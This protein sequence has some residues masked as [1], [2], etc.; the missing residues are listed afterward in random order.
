MGWRTG[1]FAWSKVQIL[2][3]N[4]EFAA[5]HGIRYRV[6][7]KRRPSHEKLELSLAKNASVATSLCC[8]AF[9]TVLKTGE[10]LDSDDS[11]DTRDLARQ[12]TLFVGC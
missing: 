10:L 11:S 8:K 12:R 3:S 9:I 7:C 4:A 5:E 6:R 1:E 2:H